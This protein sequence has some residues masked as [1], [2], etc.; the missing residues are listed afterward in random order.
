MAVLNKKQETRNA[1]RCNNRDDLANF[2]FILKVS[3]FSE[4]Y[5]EP[6]RTSMMKLLA[7]IAESC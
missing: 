3:M 1:T 7:K 6:S 4:V 2:S 5:L